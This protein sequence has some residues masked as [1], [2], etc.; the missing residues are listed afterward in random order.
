VKVRSPRLAVNLK[1]LLTGTLARKWLDDVTE[2]LRAQAGAELGLVYEDG[3]V[4]VDGVASIVDPENWDAVARQF[5][6][7]EDGGRRA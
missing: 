7:T 3:G 5:L 6:L 1:H 2:A 4:L